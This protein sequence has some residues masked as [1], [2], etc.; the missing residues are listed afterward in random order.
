MGVRDMKPGYL[1]WGQRGE[2]AFKRFLR[3]TVDR[4]LVLTDVELGRRDLNT[5]WHPSP[6]NRESIGSGLGLG[7]GKKRAEVQFIF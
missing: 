3:T 6:Q 2:D 1:W 7:R 5:R 4:I